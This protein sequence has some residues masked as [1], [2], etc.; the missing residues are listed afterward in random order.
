MCVVN[1][2]IL[3]VFGTGNIFVFMRL[4]EIK[5]ISAKGEIIKDKNLIFIFHIKN[6]NTSITDHPNRLK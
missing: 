1:H 2:N 3:M 6:K 4:D 5:K